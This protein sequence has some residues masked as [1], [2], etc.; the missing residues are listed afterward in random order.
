V[1]WLLVLGNLATAALLIVT[2]G[3]R[4]KV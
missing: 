3:S 2:L 4:P 1:G